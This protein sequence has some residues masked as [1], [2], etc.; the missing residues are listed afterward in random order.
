M[1][2]RCTSPNCVAWKYYG[3]RG[4]VVCERWRKFANFLEDM[5]PRPEGRTIDRIDVNGNYEPSNCRW[6]TDKEQSDNTRIAKLKLG[7]NGSLYTIKE[8]ADKFRIKPGT[9][10]GRLRKG[11]TVEEAVLPVRSKRAEHRLL[12][13]DGVYADA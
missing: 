9:L 13:D 12:S 4:I 10:D 11:C 3:G 6:A 8:L 5:G 7:Y 1:I 2:Q